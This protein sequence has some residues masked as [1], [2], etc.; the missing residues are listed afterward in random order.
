MDSSAVATE[1]YLN[2][3]AL[4]ALSCFSQMIH[5]KLEWRLKFRTKRGAASEVAMA[6]V[7]GRKTNGN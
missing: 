6:P 5:W 3:E 1:T 2:R 4:S 7:L